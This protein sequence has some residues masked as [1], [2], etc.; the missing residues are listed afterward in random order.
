MRNYITNEWFT[1]FTIFSLFTI[2]AAKYVNSIRFNDFIAVI[3]NSKYLKLYTR[4]QKFIDQFD[5]LL[6][7][8]LVLSSSIFIFFSYNTFI[9]PV[10]FELIPFLKLL[11]AVSTIIIVKTL[12]E[13]LVG[14][15]FEIDGLIDSYLFQ[16]TT[17]KNYSGIL[18]FVANLFLLYSNKYSEIII[19]VSISLICL[20]NLIGFITSFKNHQKTINLNFFYFLLYL[21]ALEIGPYVLLYKVIRE[22]NT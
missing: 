20:I 4:D 9:T 7:I 22:Y 8:N 17:F 14:S 5:S 12:I 15:L 18:F 1:L 19:Y 10:S 2:V 16:K 3:G 6:F 13:R 21:C 11:F